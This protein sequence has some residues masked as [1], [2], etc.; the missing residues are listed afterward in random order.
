M[1]LEKSL[2]H[3]GTPDSWDSAQLADDYLDK[4]TQLPAE[5]LKKSYSH[6]LEHSKYFPKIAD[7]M[8]PVRDEL[9]GMKIKLTRLKMALES[10]VRMQG[11]SS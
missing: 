2:S 3:F 5:L 1:Y 11:G 6:I 7:F 10:S 4:L 8:E 9:S